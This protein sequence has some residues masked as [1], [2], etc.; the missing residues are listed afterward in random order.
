[1]SLTSWHDRASAWSIEIESEGSPDFALDLAPAQSVLNVFTRF[2]AGGGLG[3][4]VIS[5]DLRGQVH[6]TGGRLVYQVAGISL[7][8]SAVS[9]LLRMAVHLART[10]YAMWPVRVALGGTSVAISADALDAP[11]Q[12]SMP[13]PFELTIQPSAHW[14]NFQCELEGDTSDDRVARLDE[15]LKVWVE[16]VR[17]TGL[18]VGDPLE[19]APQDIRCAATRPVVGADFID[20]HLQLAAVPPQAFNGLVNM[21][22]FVAESD[23]AIR[24]VHLT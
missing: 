7:F 3:R 11:P 23:G 20:W 15:T 10:Q 24:A 17:S 4:H 21:L 18:Q 16:V 2:A 6:F 19:S 22:S 5:P 12:M 8:A 1:M 9:V 14:V 13:L